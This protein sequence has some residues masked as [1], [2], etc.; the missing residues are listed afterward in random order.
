MKL[1][2]YWFATIMVVIV[3]V[4]MQGNA[5][6]YNMAQYFPL[7][8]GDEWTY[9][10]TLNNGAPVE[11]KSVV[12]GP[13]LVNGVETMKIGVHYRVM[14]SEGLKTYRWDR[15]E[16][17]QFYIYDPPELTFPAQFSLGDSYQQS[18]TNSIYSLDDGTLLD[19]GTVSET[20]TLEAVEDVSVPAGTF[21]DCLKVHYSITYQNSSGEYGELEDSNW[22]FRNVGGVKVESDILVRPPGGNGLEFD[23]SIELIEYTVHRRVC[24]ATLAL[25]GDSREHDLIILREFRDEVLSKTPAGQEIIELYYEWSPFILKAMEEDEQFTQEVKQLLDSFLIIIGEV[26]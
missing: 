20:V 24:P 8:Q 10:S 17:G 9:L 26:E 7:H 5:A 15:P 3:I 11:I 22:F 12:S 18:Y 6:A 4:L 19:T 14:D 1:R 2:K 13:E 16:F 23:L 21:K 25:K